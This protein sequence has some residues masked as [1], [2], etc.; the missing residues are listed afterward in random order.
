[1]YFTVQEVL[2]D[3]SSACMCTGTGYI[4]RRKAIQSIGGWPLAESGED[5]M[6]SALLSDAGWEIAFVRENL[7]YGI[8][9]GSMRALL[10]QRMRW[11]RVQPITTLFLT[12]DDRLDRRW[13]RG[14][15]VPS[16]LCRSFRVDGTNDFGPASGEYPLHAQRLR[17]S[18][19]GSGTGTAAI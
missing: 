12:A 10:K 8:C 16:F 2:N 14:S 13:N 3:A 15:Q 4:A 18:G 7:Q 11:V 9:P 5:Y 19:F 17:T 6:C 1:M